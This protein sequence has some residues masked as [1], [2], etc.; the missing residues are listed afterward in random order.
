MAVIG[1]AIFCERPDCWSYKRTCIIGDPE[2]RE[3]QP[4]LSLTLVDGKI[5]IDCMDYVDDPDFT[6]AGSG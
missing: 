3:M 4:R 1:D 6:E 2:K 5:F